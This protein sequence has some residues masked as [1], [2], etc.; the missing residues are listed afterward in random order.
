MSR[1]DEWDPRLI[2]WVVLGILAF[3]AFVAWLVLG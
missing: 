2:R 3:W 1:P